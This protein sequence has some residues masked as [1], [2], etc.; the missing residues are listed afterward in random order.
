M[1]YTD[2]SRYI[3]TAAS[4]FLIIGLYHQ[5]YKMFSTK[6][7]DDFSVLMIL[8]LVICQLTWINYGV[9]LNEWPIL[10]LSVLELPAGLLALL[11]YYKFRKRDHV[12]PNT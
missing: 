12:I 4:I 1:T 11:G 3:V 5:V 9:V 7:T 8:A 6:S 10:V 2:F